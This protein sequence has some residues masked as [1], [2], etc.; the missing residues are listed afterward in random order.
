[1]PWDPYGESGETDGAPPSSPPRRR[2]KSGG[3][4][5]LPPVPEGLSGMIAGG[6]AALLL[7]IAVFSSG[8]SIQPEEQ[9]VVL[10]LGKFHSI[11]DP[12]FHMKLPFGIDRVQKVAT[13][14]VLKEEFGFRT[15][16]AGKETTYS[17]E[18]HNS[19][20]LMLTGDLNIADVEWVVQYR[21]SDPREYLFQNAEPVKTLRDM[22]ESIMRS[23]LGDRTVDQVLTVG[24]A[25]IENAVK[26]QL[27]EKMNLY[28]TGVNI[29]TVQLQNVKP[30]EPVAP[31]F[32][33][34]NK[35]E[36]DREKLRNEAQRE[37]NK[38]I[39]LARGEALNRLQRAEG[40]RINRINEASG[41][42]SKFLR[43]YEEYLKAPDVTRRRLYIEAME[44][45]LPRVKEI[46]IVDPDQK[47]LLPLLD[48]NKSPAPAEGGG[49]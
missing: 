31:A 11:S 27:Q 15:Q 12:G 36:Q 19:E 39:P 46:F 13:G 35:A 20:S 38:R 18:S 49:K 32:N 34:V 21:I 41:E 4:S 16:S 47:G 7:I 29:V 8:Y 33:E 24:R 17:P 1:M 28:K 2:K 25:E 44:A 5:G 26:T 14:R 9:G 22:S 40:Y 30:P 45:V 43:I 37:Y 48:L 23:V 3:D 6:L 42:V 10:R